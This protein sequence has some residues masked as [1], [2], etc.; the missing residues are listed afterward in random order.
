MRAKPV[1][2]FATAQ[3][4]HQRRQQRQIFAVQSFFGDNGAH[5]MFERRLELVVDVV[6]ECVRD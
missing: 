3:M 4:P 5:R 1:P 6:C 2:Q